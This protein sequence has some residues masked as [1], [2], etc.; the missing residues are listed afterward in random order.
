MYMMHD[1]WQVSN[2]SVRTDISLSLFLFLMNLFQIENSTGEQEHVD[3][4]LTLQSTHIVMTNGP[5]IDKFPPKKMK[6]KRKN[7]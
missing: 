2:V 7:G 5:L 1:V 3:H 4:P 6:S